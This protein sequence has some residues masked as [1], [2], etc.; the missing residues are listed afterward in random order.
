MCAPHLQ[1]FVH[2][3]RAI[4]LD[5]VTLSLCSICHIV[6]VLLKV[7]SVL[8]KEVNPGTKWSDS[9]KKVGYNNIII[10]M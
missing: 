2:W 4:Y 10:C 3:Y 8:K 7:K 5:L 1:P 6:S 9:L